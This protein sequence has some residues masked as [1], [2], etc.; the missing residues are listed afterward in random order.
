MSHMRDFG[1]KP[2]WRLV[3]A[4]FEGYKVM[5]LEWILLGKVMMQW[6]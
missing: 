3:T 2:S 5:I 1:R 6:I 4:H